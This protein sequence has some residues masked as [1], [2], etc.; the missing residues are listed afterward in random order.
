VSDPLITVPDSVWRPTV[1]RAQ[2]LA[3]L[4]E[5]RRCSKKQINEAARKLKIGRTMVYRLLARF[6]LSEQATS[7]LPSKPGRKPGTKELGVNQEKV[8]DRLIRQFYLSRQKPSVAALHRT[9]ALECFQAQ[10]PI[11]SYKAVRTRVRALDAQE[12]VRAREGAKA[13]ADQFR[14][15][16]AW[17]S[18]SEPLELVQVDH[19]LVDLIVVDDWERQPIGRPWLSLAIDVA[20]RYVLGF[21]LSLKTPSSAAVAQTISQA[22]LPKA[23]YLAALQ[24]DAEWPAC[25]LPSLLHVDNAKEFRARALRRGCEQQGIQIVYR[26]PLQP[27]F[28]G[29]VERLIGTLM[30]EVHLLPG[31]TFSSVA[32][33]GTYDS[34]GQAVMTLTELEA[35]LAWQILGVYHLRPHSALGCAPMAAWQKGMERIRTPV[36][37][38]ADPKRFYLDFLPFEQRLIGRAGLRLFNIFYWHGALGSYVHDGKKHIVRYDPRDLSR[39]YL[40]EADGSYLEIPYRDLSHRPASLREVQSGVRRLRSLGVSPCDERRLFEA[41]A[42]Q[43]EIV[44]NSRNKTLKARRQAQQRLEKSPVFAPSAKQQAEANPELDNP[45]DPFPFEIWRE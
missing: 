32:K 7:L 35:W 33:R 27:H 17:V 3:Q 2:V 15:I 9:I 30:G 31:A 42:K 29:H 4:G 11:P 12:V 38:P 39:V 41:I 34:V 8:V 1:Q 21:F 40:L 43:R 44:E 26:P 36:R 37:E 22:V 6:R 16:K 45:V 23:A 10:I 13:A 19:T 25:G 18:A 14:P 20:T 5:T 28:G 24:V